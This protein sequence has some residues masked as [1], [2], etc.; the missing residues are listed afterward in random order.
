MNSLHVIE[1]D[2]AYRNP[3]FRSIRSEK[4]PRMGLEKENLCTQDTKFEILWSI[5]LVSSMTLL[6]SLLLSIYKFQD[7]PLVVTKSSLFSLAVCN[8][9]SKTIVCKVFRQRTKVT[10][11]YNIKKIQKLQN[12]QKK[13]K[14]RCRSTR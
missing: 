12:I 9:A 1:T 2:A 14:F 7:N 5:S 11:F 4:L 8:F 13:I 6:T 10:I 3:R